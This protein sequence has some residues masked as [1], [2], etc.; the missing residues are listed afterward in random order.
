[1]NDDEMMSKF[2]FLL[3]QKTQFSAQLSAQQE[4][5]DARMS[6][7]QKRFDAQ[8]NGS[9]ISRNGPL[10]TW[11]PDSTRTVGVVKKKCAMASII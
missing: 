11:R 6:A 3:A 8:Q 9:A 4:Q 1:M 2:E 7:Q 5:F 10:P